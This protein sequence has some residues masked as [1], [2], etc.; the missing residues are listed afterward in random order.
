M[1]S[2]KIRPEL[3]RELY[4]LAKSKGQAMT[5]VVNDIIEVYLFDQKIKSGEG[6]AFYTQ[7]DLKT[8]ENEKQFCM[9]GG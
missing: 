7:A 8:A 4:I 6:T 3:V 1:Y 2:P 5:V 9:K